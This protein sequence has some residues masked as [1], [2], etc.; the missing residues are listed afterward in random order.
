MLGVFLGL[1]AGASYGTASIIIRTAV[2]QIPPLP[3]V[4]L[5]LFASLA[6]VGFTALLVQRESLLT[7]PIEAFPWFAVIGILN[8]PVARYFNYRGVEGI[9]ASRA[10]TLI[11]SQPFFAFLLAMALLGE[12]LSVPVVAGAISCVL[13][14][15]LLLNSEQEGRRVRWWG[16][17]FSLV[18]AACYGTTGVLIKMTVP[19]L[20][21]PLAAATIA[22][23]FGTLAMS[24][25]GFAGLGDHVRTKTKAAALF[26]LCG[27]V[28][29][30]GLT[31]QYF[32]LSM[33]PV[34]IISPLV[35]TSPFFTFLGARLFLRTTEKITGQLICAALL[36]VFGIVLIVIRPAIA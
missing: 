5:S 30:I 25:A 12:R 31:S 21:P 32:A 19:A 1:L 10:Q 20:A 16:Y 11:A 6:A 4:L 17:S 3:G 29:A 18:A 23:I 13:G 34:V 36:V 15:A 26:G 28:S 35:A 2:R 24:S 27:V 33:T 14:I 8:Y 7:V 22:L 9:G